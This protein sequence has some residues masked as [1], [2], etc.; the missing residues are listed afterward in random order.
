[1]ERNRL[2]VF[3]F[4]L[5]LLF[6]VL[7]SI[8]H[9]ETKEIVAE[10]TY[11]MGDGETPLI[12]QERALV[13]AKRTAV[14]QAGTYVQSYSETRNYQLTADEVQVIAS[15]IMEV[16]VLDTRRTV[17]GSGINFWVKIKAVVTTDKIEDMAA[18]VKEM[19][20]ADDYKKLQEN[21]DKSRQ[22]V[23]ALKQQLG[24]A[25]SEKDRLQIKTQIAAKE[26][27]FQ[28]DTWFDR[29]NRRMAERE[30]YGA[31]NA[32]NEAIS[33]NPGFGWAYFRRGT[34]HADVGEY[35]EAIGDFNKALEINPRLAFAYFGKGRALEKLGYRRDAIAAYRTFI[36]YAAPNQHRLVE[37]AR[38]RI[39]TLRREY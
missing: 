11:V 5:M 4:S 10:G 7:P 23:A 38:H 18:K 14:E 17:D 13:A 16:T 24:Q 2:Q 35:Q 6:F 9:A 37:M 3:V 31:I 26:T 22:E 25:G 39:I 36:D 12:A 1:M 34:A 29:G 15:G 21:Y 27:L 33:L 30:Y 28:A 32:Y 8:G 20:L 19:S